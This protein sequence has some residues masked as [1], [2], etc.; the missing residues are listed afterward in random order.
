MKHPSAETR[1]GEVDGL[2]TQRHNAP[3]SE[4]SSLHDL[5]RIVDTPGIENVNSIRPR[6][7]MVQALADDVSLVAYREKGVES[8]QPPASFLAQKE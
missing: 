5:P 2:A 8:C 7:E 1:F 6:Q 4:R 3:V